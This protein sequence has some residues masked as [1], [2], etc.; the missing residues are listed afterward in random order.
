MK[1]EYVPLLHVQRGLYRIP[2][3]SERFRAYLETMVDPQTRDLELPLVAMNPMGKDHLPT[4]LD[5]LLELDADGVAAR[6]VADAGPRLAHVEGEFKMTLVVADDAGGGWTNRYFSE[7]SHRF[8]TKPY[9][10]RGWL[11]SLLWTSEAPSAQT[12]REETLM[13]LYRAAHIQQ[14]SFAQTLREMLA[15]EGFAMA[16]AG[17]ARPALDVDELAY[18]REVIASYLDAKD[19]PALMACLFGDKAADSLGYQPLGL[20]ERAGLALALYDVRLHCPER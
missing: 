9:H 11:T 6:A 1:L 8:E 20:S 2:R 14:H 12:V 15:Q 18:T 4:L 3:G 13:T 17:C 5:A 19:Q 16:M 7:F 10:K